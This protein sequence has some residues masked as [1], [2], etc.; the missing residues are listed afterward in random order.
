MACAT[1]NFDASLPPPLAPFLK[2]MQP[3]SHTLITGDWLVVT[4]SSFIL[5]EGMHE[6]VHRRTRQTQT[7]THKHTHMHTHA[8]ARA[9]ARAHSSIR[10]S[11]TSTSKRKRTHTVRICT[12]PGF[13]P[14][15]RLSTTAGPSAVAPAA[16]AASTPLASLMPR[17][18]NLHAPTYPPMSKPSSA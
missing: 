10:T 8:H 6:A 11:R 16:A 14:D 2:H 3:S 1:R 4:D 7:R 13:G 9:H 18:Q 5:F 15:S 12:T 17:G